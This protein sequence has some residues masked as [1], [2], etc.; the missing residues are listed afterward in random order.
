MSPI[1]TLCNAG[2]GAT[3]TYLLRSPSV[4]KDDAQMQEYI[5]SGKALLVQGDALKK[6]DV[7]HGWE[8]AQG[9]SPTSQVDLV[10]FGVGKSTSTHSCHRHHLTIYQQAAPRRSV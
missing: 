4:F 6:E 10:L 9:A 8:T 2:K 1:L 7:A 5:K 3:V